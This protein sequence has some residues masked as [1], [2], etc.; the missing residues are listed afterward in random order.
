MQF[1][2][3]IRGVNIHYLTFNYIKGI[4]GQ[5]CGNMGF[6]YRN[7]S[8]DRFLTSAFRTYKWSG[9][10]QLKKLDCNFVKKVMEMI[11]SFD[12]AEVEIMRK[13]V[14]DQL[15]RQVNTTAT[16]AVG[17]P[18]APMGQQVPTPPISPTGA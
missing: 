12:P 6:S 10:R 1:G 9:I 4:L 14:L 18:V 5:G 16:E 2:K 3:R 7:F 11:R 8:G 13:N 15:E 17:A